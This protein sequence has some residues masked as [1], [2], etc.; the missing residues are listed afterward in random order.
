MLRPIRIVIECKDRTLGVQK[1]RYSDT[2][3]KYCYSSR[4][5]INN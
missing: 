1:F 4:L 3:N 5:S 2:Y